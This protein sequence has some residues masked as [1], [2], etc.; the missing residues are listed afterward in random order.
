[1]QSDSICAKP[2]GEETRPGTKKKCSHNLQSDSL[3]SGL[4]KGQGNFL[5]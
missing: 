2:G 3:G 4:K 5:Q 1:M